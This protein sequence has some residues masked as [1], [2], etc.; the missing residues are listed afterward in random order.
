MAV[1]DQ[2]RPP[3]FGFALGRRLINWLYGFALL[4]AL[5]RSPGHVYSRDQLRA[6]AWPDESP[7]GISDEAVNSL[8]R[9][10]RRRLIEI[11]PGHRTPRDAGPGKP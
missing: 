5:V 1:E 4:G 6:I 3:V 8:I 10:L 2:V 7:A 9:R 11:G